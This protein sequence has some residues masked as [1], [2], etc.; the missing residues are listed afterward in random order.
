M[1]N[2]YKN[3]TSLRPGLR[4]QRAEMGATVSIRHVYEGETGV[5]RARASGQIHTQEDI[6]YLCNNIVVTPDSLFHDNFFSSLYRATRRHGSGG[7]AY[8]VEK[9]I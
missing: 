6:L 4:R 7:A 5:S 3:V 9:K 1:V 8:A 2:F